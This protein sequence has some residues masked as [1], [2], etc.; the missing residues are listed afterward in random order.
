M[1]AAYVDLDPGIAKY[2][3]AG[4]HDDEAGSVRTYYFLGGRNAR[5]QVA[6]SSMMFIIMANAALAAILLGTSTALL[7]WPTPAAVLPGSACG[8]AFAG[9]SSLHGARQYRDLWNRFTPLSPT[10]QG[11]N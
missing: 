1:R 4:R 7:A 10:S 11:G 8:L 3:M 5:S 6:G 2:L 9:A